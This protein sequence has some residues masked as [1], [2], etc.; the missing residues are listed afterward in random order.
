MARRGKW[1]DAVDVP[2]GPGILPQVVWLRDSCSSQ[3]CFQGMSIRHCCSFD[4]FF[5]SIFCHSE[6]QISGKLLAWLI[7]RSCR[8]VEVGTDLGHLV[9]LVHLTFQYKVD[10]ALSII[11]CPLRIHR[12]P[13]VKLFSHGEESYVERTRRG[14][15]CRGCKNNCCAIVCRLR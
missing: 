3:L 9:R 2:S 14:R 15:R 1:R 4:T 10:E 6:G 12:L 11:S 5:W 13:R 7:T 8:L